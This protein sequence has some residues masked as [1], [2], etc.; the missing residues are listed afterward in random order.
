[1]AGEDD[2]VSQIKVTGGPEGAAQIEQFAA[3]GAAAFDKLDASANKAAADIS[4]STQQ[5]GAA[6]NQAA[7][8]LQNI[9]APDLSKFAGGLSNIE[10]GMR[11]LVTSIKPAVQ[12]IGRFTQRIALVGSATAAAA[13]GLVEGARRIAQS[14]NTQSSALEKNVKSQ[15]DA[16]NRM[17]EGQVAAIQLASS[18]DGLRKQLVKGEITYAQYGEAIRKSNEDAAEQARVA[19]DVANAQDRAKEANDR[20]QKSLEN[21]QAMQKLTDKFGGPLTSALIQFGNQAESVRQRF[22]QAF[23]P[24]LAAAVD[25]VGNVL[26]KNSGA[27]QKFL[28]EAGSKLSAVIT[29]NA[30]AIESA[31]SSLGSAFASVFTGF[32]EAAPS[33]LAF[34]NEG[35][36]PAVRA[37]RDALNGLAG[38]IN[39]VFGTQIT[40]GTI[41]FIALFLQL[42]GVIRI[43]FTAFRVLFNVGRLLVGLFTV[44]FGFFGIW[45]VL[46]L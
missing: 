24:G 12:A 18:Q 1:M 32:L 30:P 16:N 38:I 23:G 44:F 28:D 6:G 26:S 14:T 7:A 31:L 13:V 4:R 17:A 10:G 35:V 27:I 2:L 20:L 5:I 42:T 39:S 43:A 41:A 21:Q 46:I 36:V 3:Q 25:V 37:V 15:Q 22:V 11:G 33:I 40:G 9:K 19:S 8:G 34:F 45:G 29:A